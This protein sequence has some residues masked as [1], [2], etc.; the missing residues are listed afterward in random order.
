L[1]AF[2]LVPRMVGPRCKRTAT[3][4]HV[5]SEWPSVPDERLLRMRIRC[6]SPAC[7]LNQDPESGACELRCPECGAGGVWCAEATS[8]HLCEPDASQVDLEPYK[9]RKRVPDE[10]PEVWRCRRGHETKEPL[11]PKKEPRRVGARTKPPA[12]GRNA[13][14]DRLVL[15]CSCWT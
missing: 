7:A 14:E 11:R 10:S 15:L 9:G 6:E 5:F 8:D 1:T 13:T 12:P 2:S 4:P 3:D